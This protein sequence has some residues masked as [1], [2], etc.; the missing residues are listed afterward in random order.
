M[1]F[2]KKCVGQF[3]NPRLYS[4]SHLADTACDSKLKSDRST[5]QQL[6]IIY[7]TFKAAPASATCSLVIP[8]VTACQ[9]AH[10]SF[11]VFGRSD[12]QNFVLPVSYQFSGQQAAYKLQRALYIGKHR[13][14]RAQAVT[15]VDVLSPLVTAKDLVLN[16]GKSQNRITL[17]FA[18]CCRQYS[19]CICKAA[20][21]CH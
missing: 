14:S 2:N 5:V 20:W 7:D 6:C 3:V 19:F 16:F 12:N 10:Y 11:T 8:L 17:L 13:E 1:H 21:V 18:T 4:V 15:G 9:S